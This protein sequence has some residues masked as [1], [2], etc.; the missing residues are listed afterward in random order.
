[1]AESKNSTGAAVK[2]VVSI[3]AIVVG[4]FLVFGATTPA[5]ADGVFVG[6]ISLVLAIYLWSGVT[7]GQARTLAIVLILL[8]AYAFIRGFGLLDLAVLR[9]LGGIA[10]IVMGVILI[11]PFLRERFGSKSS[12]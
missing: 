3:A 1:M 6:S 8:A 4:L 12:S 9:Q 5:I 11:I 10:A 7:T 2:L